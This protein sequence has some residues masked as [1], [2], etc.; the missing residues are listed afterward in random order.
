M[1]W[2]MS[3][4]VITTTCLPSTGSLGVGVLVVVAVAA[5]FKSRKRQGTRLALAQVR[6]WA[7]ASRYCRSS[8]YC[9]THVADTVW[10]TA[11]TWTA[12]SP[13]S[14]IAA[15]VHKMLVSALDSP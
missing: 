7:K 2:R 1:A 13:A 8:S 5:A 3:T 4:I 9:A 10:S 6:W 15:A 11:L 12:L 14:T